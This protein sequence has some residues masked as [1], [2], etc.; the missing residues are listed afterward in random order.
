VRL[1]L[2]LT[3]LVPVASFAQGM[4][5]AGVIDGQVVDAAGR[6]VS[7]AIVSISGTGISSGSPGAQPSDPPRIL[8][9]NDGRF[10][11]RNLMDGS[12]TIT[13]VKGGYAEGASGR[14]RPGGSTQAILV[15]ESARTV[16]TTIRER[17]VPARPSSSRTG[18]P[19]RCRF[20]CRAAR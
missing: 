13:V 15:N 18:S 5:R 17:A 16:D 8:T 3:L 2:V 1:L 12:F 11:F 7:G 19:H 4:R 20:G 9:G 14:R 6:P 10:V